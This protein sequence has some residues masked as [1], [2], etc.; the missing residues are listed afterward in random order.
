MLWLIKTNDIFL[1]IDRNLHTNHL[2]VFMASIVKEGKYYK[3]YYLYGG[4]RH[5]QSLKT[6]SKKIAEKIKLDIENKI[7][8]DLFNISEYSSN[9]IK[10]L[11]EFFEEAEK[12]SK[13]NKAKSSCIRESRVFRNFFAFCGNIPLKTVTPKLIEKYK[14]HLQEEK[15]FMAS[16][17]NIELRHLSSSFSLAVN[18]S[19][20][21]ENP[22]KKSKKI[23]TPKKKPKF[24]T[25]KQ[26]KTLLHHTE[27]RAV[28]PLIFIALNTGARIAEVC[29]LKWKNIDLENS[30][31]TL[32]GKGSKERTIPI[33]QKLL[34]YLN[35]LPKPNEWVI[36]GG[37]IPE[38]KTK[39]FRKY[40]DQ[41][42][43]NEFTFHNLRDTY[44]S[45]LVQ[46]GINLKVIQ[47]LL[48]HE[49]IQTT[50]IYAHLSPDSRIAAVKIL[51]DKD[52]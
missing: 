14:L 21:L 41:I 27:G 50:L 36:Q 38:D 46:S 17:I 29:S 48:G 6:S 1:P 39:Q 12:Y 32:F 24:L 42:G 34:N 49:S 43:L 4:K 9:N 25:E 52:F 22:F 16:G 3:I 8:Q 47:D 2:G 19:Y 11:L 35:N 28:Y 45:W 13:V 23:K 5:K 44:A 40:A 31:L 37:R 15:G 30:M 18:Y 10:Y 7:A 51:D 26:A 20:I 33:P